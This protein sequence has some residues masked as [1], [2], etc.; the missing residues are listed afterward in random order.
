M[1]TSTGPIAEFRLKYVEPIQAGLYRDSTHGDRRKSLKMLG[2]L[3]D[4]EFNLR[5]IL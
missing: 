1:L 5:Q 2:V 3:K 4:G